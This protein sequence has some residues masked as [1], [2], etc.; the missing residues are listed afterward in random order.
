VGDQVE[1]VSVIIPAY[2]EE[3]RIENTLR[4]VY[5][6]EWIKELIVVDDGS[7]DQTATIA[8]KWTNHVIRLPHNA[9]KAFALKAGCDYATSPIL[10]FLDADLEESTSFAKKL[11]EPMWQEDVDMTIAVLP[12][13]RNGGFGLVKQF[14]AWGIYY[15]TGRRLHAPLCGQRAIKKVVIEACYQGDR[16]FG[17]EVGLSL[18]CL[19]AG[20]TIQEVPIPFTHRETG[21][22]VPGFLHRMKQG[23]SVCQALLSRR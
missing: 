18:D 20:Y 11:V 6:K 15:K 22:R 4:S 10:L 17:I 14:A 2:N 12:A 5:Q 9:G 21:K 13:A 3:Q 1:Q 7:T 16:G 19:L 8:K 23:V